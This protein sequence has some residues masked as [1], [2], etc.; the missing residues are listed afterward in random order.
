MQWSLPSAEAPVRQGAAL[1]ATLIIATIMAH[2]AYAGETASATGRSQ[3]TIV[4]PIAV[5]AVAPLE[6]GVIAVG[7]TQGGT[8]TVDPHTGSSS[9]TGSLAP[10]CPAGSGCFARPGVFAVTGEPTRFYRIAAPTSAT[11]RRNGGGA[12]DLTV[13][14]IRLWAGSTAADGDRGRLD[15]SGRGTFTVGGTLA[16]PP[17][18]RPGIYS[19]EVAVVVSYD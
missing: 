15:N 10:A 4:E 1:T 13:E 12:S 11:A 18:T 14:S 8:I 6:F 17:A 19:A 3:A 2:P 7:P 16:I 9:F 5:K